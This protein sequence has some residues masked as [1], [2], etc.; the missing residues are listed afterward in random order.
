MKSKPSPCSG[1]R[2]RRSLRTLGIALALATALFIPKD[3]AAKDAAP[4]VKYLRAAPGDFELL[5]KW[6]TQRI[7]VT[8]LSAD[9]QAR[10]VTGQTQF[11]SANAKIAKVGAD[12]IVHPVADGETDIALS[13][14]GQKQ[15]LHVRVRGLRSPDA[16][17]LN[18][19]E[20]L[21]QTS[22]CN[23]VQCH[24]GQ[25]G[26]G[27]LRLSLF[28]SDPAADFDALTRAAGGRRIDRTDPAQSLLYLKATGA[29][30]HP[31]AKPLAPRETE[32]LL[33]WLT[34]GAKLRGEAEPEIAT[35][36][37]YPEARVMAKGE[38]QHLLVMGLYS[39]G[40]RRDVTADAHFHAADAKIATV[41]AATVHSEGTGDGAVVATYL[42]KAAVFRLTTPQAGPKVF[43]PLAANN[44][45]D[46]LVYAKLKAMGI[47][48]SPLAS[49][50]E[51]L[52]RLYLDTI[53]LLPT[54]EEA[55][56]FL[57][58]P[59]PAKR[60]G[61]IDRLMERVEFTDFW[62]LKWGDL[63]R[64]KS[65]FPV[66]LWPKAV[67]VYYEWLRE[68]I[69]QN[70]PYDQFARELLTSTGS[71]FKVGPANFVRAVPN[72]D[73]RTL[74]ETAA[75]VFMGARIGCARCHSHP[76]ESWSPEDD[77]GFGAY[78]AR[79]NFKN[80]GE[81][82]EEV[83]YPDFKLSLRD[84][85]TRLV[86]QPQVPGGKPLQLTAE[87]DPRGQLAEWLTAP[88]NP[89]FT[90]NIVNRIWYWLLGRGIIEAP[91]DLRPTNPPTNPELLGYL[92][93]ELVSHHY[94]LRHIYRL[95]LNSRTYQLSSQT[96][97]W[98]AADQTHF[99][100]YPTRR[101]TAE[102]M[103]DAISQFT[104]TSE[105]FRSIIPEPYSNWPANFRAEQISDGN[106]ECSFLDLFGRSPRDT[107]FE[108]ERDSGLTIRQTL[109][110]LNSE[111][112]E[113]KL[114]GSP[115]FKRWITA[116]RSDAEMVD[117]IYLSTVS[118]LPSE[119]ERK[120]AV[121]YLAG[122]KNARAVGVQD[123]AWAVVNSKEFVFNH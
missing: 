114:S 91:D 1:P 78:F 73:A 24:G 44:R 34:G 85:R 19:I 23:S 33:T 123:V 87:Q 64:I 113:A 55:R 14:A 70:K 102:Q 86:V 3:A 110:L 37:L 41:A 20:P 89:Y 21:L 52:R 56:A 15:K 109:Y 99:S 120:K 79:V 7:V 49:D 95:I 12:G 117:E 35:L 27:G 40:S 62:A 105:K 54:P 121:E 31:G 108:G 115:R 13:A 103:L 93:Q 16:S 30:K 97:E 100:H 60:A 101:L 118:R 74:G 8:G 10:D 104:E 32:I 9:G 82:K 66:R 92:Q 119:S 112:L 77:L 50:S 116:N 88:D 11:R 71:N 67:A 45:V 36:E 47:P 98:N 25:G 38:S 58:D 84:P 43:P 111:Q 122:K 63:L 53:G 75:L 90:A 42:R 72:K 68:S 106:T 48:P 94:D 5:G 51:F 46:E 61:L 29:L 57:A 6:A 17:F 28:G 18:A 81:W 80:T 65:E 59:N 39:D 107:P 76:L 4:K 2:R 69:A 22:G 83:V 26:K 96:N